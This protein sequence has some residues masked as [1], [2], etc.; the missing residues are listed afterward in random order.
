MISFIVALIALLV[1]GWLFSYYLQKKVGIDKNRTTPAYSQQD[2]VDYMPLP[3]WKVYLIQFLNIAGTGPIFGAIAGVLFGPAA[4]LWIVLGCVLIGAMHDFMSGLI[5]VRRGG[6]SVT[7]FVGQ[8]LGGAVH[9]IIRVYAIFTLILVGTVF[10]TTPAGLLEGLTPTNGFFGGRNFWCLIIFIYYLL[11]TLLPIDTLIGKLYPLFGLA[12]LVMALGVGFGICT[13]EGA[14]PEVTEAFYSHH[15]EGLPIF[16]FLFITIA[17]GAVSGFHATQTPMMARCIENEKYARPVFYGAMI[18]EGVVALIW[19]AA[20]IK[21]ANGSSENLSQIM[22]GN[23]AVVV[24]FVCN[25][26]M[27]RVGAILAVLGVVAAPITSGDTAFRSA[28]LHASEILHIPQN[29]IWKRILISI[30]LFACSC[31]LLSIDFSVL[32]RYFGWLNQMFVVFTLWTITVYLYSHKRQFWFSLFPAIFMT[33]IC[34][35]YILVAPEGFHIQNNY[36]VY[37]ITT[38]VTVLVSLGGFS[39]MK[40]RRNELSLSP[41]FEYGSIEVEK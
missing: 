29:K 38:L 32:W 26:W 22:N 27:G 23:P 17:C 30:P 13:E 37:G 7:E 36:V 28:R 2:G 31:L 1:G 25:D 33:I 6:A 18:T 14:M 40:T 16:P 35:T 39:R 34:S 20:A 4:Y 3:A 11:A 12:L 41:D 21:Y 19:A 15:P 9:Q 24:N 8:E 10:V 5:S